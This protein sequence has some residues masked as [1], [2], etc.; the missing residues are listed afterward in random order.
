MNV[1]QII[2]LALFNADAVNVDETTHRQITQIEALA[3]AN[4]GKDKLEKIL[5]EVMEDYL[6]ISLQSNDTDFRWVGEAFDVSTL[7]LGTAT[8]KF[9][10]LPPDLVKLK[11]IRSITTGREQVTFEHMDCSLQEFKE[12]ETSQ[13]P[14]RIRVKWDIVGAGT[15]YLANPPDLTTDIELTYIAR[16]APLQIYTTGT[17]AITQNNATVTG[18]STLWIIDEVFPTGQLAD[19]IVP[20][21]GNSVGLI[22]Q[23]T[24]TTTWVE[25]SR[26]YSPIS[27]I[28]TDTALTLLGNWLPSNVASGRNYMLASV[29]SL[30]PEDHWALVDYVAMRI[31]MKTGNI[32]DYAMFKD[33]F[34]RHLNDMRVDAQRR[35]IAD[36]EF[37]EDFD[38][39]VSW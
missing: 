35:Q 5:R 19:I 3:W 37:V 22:Q 14:Q 31:A 6:L 12:L 8:K 18:T 1:A 10:R 21:S 13:S 34:D 15:L 9:Y 24:A 36:P 26:I 2:R 25:P 11:R 20:A 38:P 29:P 27:S 16:S 4:E 32:Q 28:T 17:I 23:T 7:Q 33:S 39:G 30:R